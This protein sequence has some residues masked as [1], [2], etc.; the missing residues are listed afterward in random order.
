MKPKAKDA[1]WKFSIFFLCITDTNR[2]NVMATKP[3]Y[4]VKIITV[5]V[6]M[7]TVKKKDIINNI[8]V[9]EIQSIT[10]KFCNIEKKN[11]TFPWSVT[12]L[13]VFI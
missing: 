1:I 5:G 13:V 4:I 8:L 9:A 12:K 2:G 3:A 10:V 7:F 6:P 11:F